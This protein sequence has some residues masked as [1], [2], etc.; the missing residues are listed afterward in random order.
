MKIDIVKIDYHNSRHATALI[1]L[2]EA[3]ARDPMGGA[4]GLSDHVRQNLVPALAQHS[5]AFGVLAFVNDQAAGLVNC[6]EGFSTFACQPLV[7][8]HDLVVLPAYRGQ[9]IGY[10][11]LQLVERLAIEKGCCKLTLEVLE[12]NLAAQ[13]LY[14]EF[15]FSDYQLV[16][17]NGNALFWQ[18]K[19]ADY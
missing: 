3:Y 10:L 14:R 11:M 15:G 7:N 9:R 16:P 2:L 8:V 17:E 6:F 12:G 18:K 13:K 5:T 19:L 4:D 1:E